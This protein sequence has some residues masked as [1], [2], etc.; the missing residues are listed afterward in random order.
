MTG[1]GTV[2]ILV[3]AA[4]LLAWWRVAAWRR[5]LRRADEEVTEDQALTEW[6][7][8]VRG[9]GNPEAVRMRS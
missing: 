9:T 5:R 4:V 3:L 1:L 8:T 7:A 6:F 2:A